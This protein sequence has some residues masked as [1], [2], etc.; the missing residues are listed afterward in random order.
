MINRHPPTGPRIPV[1]DVFAGPGGL[2]EGFSALET[3]GLHPFAVRLSIEK[4]PVACATLRLR[5]LARQFATPPPELLAYMAGTAPI[6]EV[7]SAYKAQTAEATGAVW[8]AELGKAAPAS[9]A[10]V[11][12]KRLAGARDWVLL[13]GPPCQAYSIAGRSRMRKVRPDFEFDER[14]FLY[15][16]YLRILADH[17]PAVFVLENVKGLITSQHGGARIVSRI[18]DDL[19]DPARAVG[20]KQRYSRGYRLYALGQRQ[21]SLFWMGTDSQDG[22]D[23]ILR[24]EEYGIPQ[25]RH[26]LFIVGVRADLPGRPATLE[27]RPPVAAEDVLTD[28]PRVR[29][30]LSRAEDSLASWRSAIADLLEL[31]WM[32]G[33]AAHSIVEVRKEIRRAIAELQVEELTP[34]SGFLAHKGSPKALAAWYRRQG[35]GLYH[36]QTR[37]HM[38][39]DLHRY[40]FA[41][42]YA[43]VHS[44]SPELKD[45]P[46]VLRPAHKNIQRA[47]DDGELFNDRFRVQLE[48]RPSTTITSH[49]SKDGHYYIHFDP[50]QCRSLTPREAARLQTFPDDYFFEGNKTEQYHQ[51]GNAVPPLLAVDISRA[52]YELLVSVGAV[53]TERRP[54]AAAAKPRRGRPGLRAAAAR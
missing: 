39:S 8:Q 5:N 37:S 1:I 3:E 47:L 41:A 25:M 16:E 4:D 11:V 17:Q 35:V 23:Y 48:D 22:E 13:G 54:R 27:T 19:C 51:I 32:S 7:V 30:Q 14:H 36:H 52:V 12:R 49:I 38:K 28:L 9:V 42:A 29:S 45:F 31:E 24:A 15:R 6:S 18:L 43:R 40:L 33:P 46:E 10:R 50:V 34:G 26:R 21:K 53:P 20:T 44:R 2:G